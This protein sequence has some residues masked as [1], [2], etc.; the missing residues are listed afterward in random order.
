MLISQMLSAG[1]WQD[2]QRRVAARQIEAESPFRH[3]SKA[4][5][6]GLTRHWRAKSLA[7]SVLVWYA[8][9]PARSRDTVA[10][11]GRLRRRS[12]KPQRLPIK[13]FGRVDGDADRRVLLASADGFRVGQTLKPQWWGRD[14]VAIA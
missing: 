13:R 5:I 2:H 14:A 10:G 1:R 3:P 9:L 12:A 8:S 11:P 7:A 6:I 4:G